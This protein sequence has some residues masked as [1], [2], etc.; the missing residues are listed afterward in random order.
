VLVLSGFR[1]SKDLVLKLTLDQIAY[2]KIWTHPMTNIA[3]RTHL[4][5][6]LCICPLQ[7]FTGCLAVDE[8]SQSVNWHIPLIVACIIR[9]YDRALH[10]G[11]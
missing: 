3:S 1:S 9:L 6:K 8:C 2:P 10:V 5:V 4:I 7:N 11:I